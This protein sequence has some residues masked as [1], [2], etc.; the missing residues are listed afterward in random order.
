M[1]IFE[2]I[3]PA[4]LVVLG[5][6]LA[7]G[8]SKLRSLVAKTETKIDDDILRIV[9]EVLAKKKEEEYTPASQ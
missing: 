4:L 9:E 7:Y 2:T 5:A 1:E 3:W 8:W 6:G